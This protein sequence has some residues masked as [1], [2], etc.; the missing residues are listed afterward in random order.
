MATR[1]SL[2]VDR[3]ITLDVNGSQQQI[4]IRAARPGLPPLL[5]VQGGPGLPVLHEV[6][7]FERLLKL[8]SDFHVVYWEQRG[9]GIATQ[10][11]ASSASMPQQIEDLR[12]VLQWLST[13]AK[14]RVIVLGISLGATYALQAVADELDR[15]RA[16]I[17]ISPDSQT[18]RADAAAHAF[19]QEQ[20]RRTSGSRLRRRMAKAGEP[21]YLDSAGLRRRASLLADLGA[22]E[23]GKKFGALLREMLFGMLRT[24]GVFGTI[25]V[26]RNMNV[27]Q[28]T[29]LPELASLDLLTTP[30]RV[31][32]PVHYVFGEQDAL[33]PPSLVE[34]LPAAIAAPASTVIRVRK[35]GHMVHFDNPDLVRSIVASA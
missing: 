27:V 4:R 30:P 29:L 34:E 26:L 9:C 14:Q 8:E 32:I 21:P 10:N 17:A 15:V 2:A 13:E 20:A 3:T 28:R 23:H 16:L 31:A 35:A 33:N 7:K 24:Y 18:E 19:L 11:D 5:I 22:I 25:K 1:T 12:T 6:P